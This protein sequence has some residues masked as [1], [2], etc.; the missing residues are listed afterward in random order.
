MK[1]VI[2]IEMDNAAFEGFRA[3]SEVH[4]I[5]KTV[6]RMV[7]SRMLCGKPEINDKLRD[8]NGNTVGFVK[9]EDA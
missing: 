8:I 7:K 6:S 3:P 5:L 2:E 1:L 4:R 9:L